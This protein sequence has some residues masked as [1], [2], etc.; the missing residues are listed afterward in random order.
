MEL[1]RFYAEK[2]VRL[3]KWLIDLEAVLTGDEVLTDQA[4][5]RRSPLKPGRVEHAK[6][7]LGFCK[8]MCDEMNLQVASLH[9]DELL[10]AV[11]GG[12]L[13]SEDVQALNMNVQRE[14][15]CRFF[16]TIPQHRLDTFMHL[17][18][19][20]EEII[21]AFPVESMMLKK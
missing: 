11:D 16:V 13:G 2:Y 17:H 15:Q 7:T 20:W 21:K 6:A 10:R 8:R 14:L 1:L 19:G 9:V 18:K 3:F 4:D 5:S 12:R